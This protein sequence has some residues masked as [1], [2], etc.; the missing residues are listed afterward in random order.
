[1]GHNNFITAN[2]HPIMIYNYAFKVK[3]TMEIL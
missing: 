1:M 3:A 2:L